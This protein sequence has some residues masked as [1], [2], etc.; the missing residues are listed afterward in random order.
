SWFDREGG[1]SMKGYFSQL[2]EQTGVTFGSS[3]SIRQDD[4]FTGN[5]ENP[6]RL[7]FE[8]TEVIE[9]RQDQVGDNTSEN[10]P[11]DI[12]ET[13]I[14]EQHHDQKRGGPSENL[15]SYIEKYEIVE[16]RQDPIRDSSPIIRKS[17]LENKE[18]RK[19]PDEEL[20]KFSH[21]SNK[22][23]PDKVQDFQIES[24]SSRENTMDAAVN[25]YNQ[26]P[27]RHAQQPDDELNK[28]LIKNEYLKQV[29][30]WVTGSTPDTEEIESLDE[31]VIQGKK[32][33]ESQFIHVISESKQKE[34]PDIQ[35]FNLSIGTISLTIEEPQ[36]EIQKK[37]PPQP[38]KVETR[39]SRESSSSRLSRHYI[40]IM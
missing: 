25:E 10:L 28:I 37:E 6:A 8:E 12:E 26:K 32:E 22:K 23:P 5:P 13:E 20:I 15:V 17:E 29:R 16:S 21:V 33:T 18:P 31:N 9:S 7:H 2:L 39:S 36:K 27:I 35:D 19:E 3:E 1:G 14:I 34:A 4:Q 24:V 38:A 11:P 40:R 30:K